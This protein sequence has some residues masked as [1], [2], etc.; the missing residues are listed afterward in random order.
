LLVNPTGIALDTAGNIYVSDSGSKAVLVFAPTANGNVAPIRNIS[1]SNT[2]FVSPTDVKV[3]SSGLV[4]VA[5]GG[6]GKIYIFASGATGNV[7]P[8]T[9]YAA[10]GTL[11]GIGL[12]P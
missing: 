1:G 8:T 4:Y 2:G 9:T 10:T 7:A 5:D 6:T 11:V 12:A 3:D